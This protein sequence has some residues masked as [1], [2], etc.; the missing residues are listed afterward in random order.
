MSMNADD[1]SDYDRLNTEDDE[2]QPARFTRPYDDVFDPDGNLL[3][4]V[5]ML[6]DPS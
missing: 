4:P 1:L 6:D 2:R 5:S 3:A